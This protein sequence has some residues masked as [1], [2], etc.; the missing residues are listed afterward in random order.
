TDILYLEA[1]G[2]YVK[3]I[4]REGTI[5]TREKISDLLQTLAGANFLRVHKSFAVAVDY[6]ERIE[7]N[8]IGIGPHLI[9]IGKQYK[10]N[11]D[12]LLG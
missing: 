4:T 10:L 11:V 3:V 8:R 6:I 9:P 12:W 1:A 7:G 5:T 2:N